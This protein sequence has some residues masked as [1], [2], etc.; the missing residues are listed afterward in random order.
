MVPP[1]P[2]VVSASPKPHNKGDNSPTACKR[3]LPSEPTSPVAKR[4]NVKKAANWDALRRVALLAMTSP[5]SSSTDKS[6][7]K[8][9]TK[10]P[11]LSSASVSTPEA[12]ASDD[13]QD[14]ASNRGTVAYNKVATTTS[15]Q[16]ADKKKQAP[17]APATPTKTKATT[18]KTTTTATAAS[19]SPSRRLRP[20]KQEIE[21]CQNR[22]RFMKA[23]NTWYKRYN[24]LVEF[25]K[26]NGHC[27]VP[28]KY[29]EC[30]ELGIW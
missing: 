22:P 21:K 2:A 6:G 3:K 10:K 4:Q 12:H 18:K 13:E 1:P 11:A 26:K 7:K 29:K 30:K 9:S 23:L 17:A 27:M 25:S 8:A 5:P 19:N 14:A 20:C 24:E 16:D 15:K 28:Q